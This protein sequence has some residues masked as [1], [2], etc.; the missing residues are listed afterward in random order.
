[1]HL[2]QVDRGLEMVN[3][4]CDISGFYNWDHTACPPCLFSLNLALHLLRIPLWECIMVC[5]PMF[6]YGRM[7]GWFPVWG[8]DA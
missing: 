5:V 1:M 3:L 6:F 8:D 7:F 2:E 4:T